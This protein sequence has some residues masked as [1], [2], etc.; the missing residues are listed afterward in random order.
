[1]PHGPWPTTVN[2]ISLFGFILVLG[3]VVDDAII[4]GESIYTKIRRT[5]TPWTT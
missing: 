3:I 2:M 5:A 1:M 4:I